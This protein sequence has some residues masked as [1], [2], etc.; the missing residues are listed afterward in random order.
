[1][2]Y[3]CETKRA[4]FDKNNGKCALCGNELVFELHG[5][6][7]REGGWEVD[8]SRPKEDGG[9]E[10]L[11]NLQPMCWRCNLKKSDMSMGDAKEKFG[12]S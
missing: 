2:S 12:N 7:E 11:N 10:H 9:T 8:H 6:R 5:N 4:I 1:M 3:S